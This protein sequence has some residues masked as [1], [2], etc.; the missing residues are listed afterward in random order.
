MGIFKPKKK[1][2]EI[3]Y[4]EENV[5]IIR[6][7]KYHSHSH[8]LQ[9]IKNSLSLI[10]KTL[11]KMSKT[12]AETAAEIRAIKDQNEKARLEILAKIKTLE[13]AIETSGNTS[14]EVDA[15]V[16]DLKAS[17]QTDDDIVPD[18]S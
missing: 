3:T 13:D 7:E 16:Q 10:I 8:E 1:T 6:G 5:I 14:D 12:Q 18:Q 17:V 2:C 11:N 9:D 15:A 4:I